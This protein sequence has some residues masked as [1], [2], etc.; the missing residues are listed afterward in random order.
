MSESYIEACLD[1]LV[2]SLSLGLQEVLHELGKLYLEPTERQ[3]QT[4]LRSGFIEV[5]EL[6][7][8]TPEGNICR[9]PHGQLISHEVMY[10]KQLLA[11]LG[12]CLYRLSECH[13]EKVNL[14][15]RKE[16]EVRLDTILKT[17][18]E[19]ILQE[20]PIKHFLCIV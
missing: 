17:S 1:D 11:L 8:I 20:V 5:K 14:L 15:I 19:I 3:I 16:G 4:L 9:V 2:D 7:K 18:L 12:H 10:R 13:S 6:L